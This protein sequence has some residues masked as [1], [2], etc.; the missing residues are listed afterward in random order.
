MRA[1]VQRVKSCTVTV[2]G[3]AVGA[4]HSGLLVYVG[5]ETGDG[6][7]DIQYLAD[8]IINLRIFPDQAGKMNL[9]LS[10]LGE[11]ILVVSQ[12]TLHADVRKGRRPSYNRAALPEEAKERYEAFLS[13]LQRRGH[14]PE[15]GRFGAKMQVTYTNDGPVTILLDSKKLF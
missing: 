4:I 8:K 11:E 12:F 5:F 13:E 3:E 14:S 9:S 15:Q 10:D 7:R 2:D 6:E 1:V